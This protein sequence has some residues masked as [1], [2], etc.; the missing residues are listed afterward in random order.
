MLHT[1]VNFMWSNTEELAKRDSEKTENYI[2][3][4]FGLLDIVRVVFS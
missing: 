4:T 2:H 3:R 1:S